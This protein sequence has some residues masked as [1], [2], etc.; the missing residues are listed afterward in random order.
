[1]HE[2]LGT[3]EEWEI[4][5]LVEFDES[6]LSQY[7][8]KHN[9]SINIPE[10]LPRRP[11]LISYFL[12]TAIA[13]D[14]ESTRDLSASM[15]WNVLLDRIC[16]REVE[17]IS[18]LPLIASD[19]KLIYGGLAILARKRPSKLG[20]ITLKDVAGIYAE[21]FKDEPKGAALAQLMR[22]PGLIS[23]GA[24]SLEHVGATV[25]A[26]SDGTKEFISEDLVDIASTNLLIDAIE[27]FDHEKIKSCRGM[28]K[29][30]GVA[31]YEN[32]AFNIRQRNFDEICISKFLA[33][34]NGTA[35]DNVIQIDLISVLP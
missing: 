18:N 32:I 26:L 6:Q 21:Q 9:S 7:L 13:S 28:I 24:P 30:L 22:L 33:L 11:L 14:I 27:N 15:G 35:R 17:Q 5:R 34:V 2:S 23:S 25:N 29:A 1:M 12:N 20:P 8:A 4:L 31:G 10:W 16:Q 19:L 3:T